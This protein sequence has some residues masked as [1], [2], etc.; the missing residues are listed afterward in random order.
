MSCASTPRT[1]GAGSSSEDAARS[2]PG[3]KRMI[4]TPDGGSFADERRPRPHR[5]FRWLAVA[6]YASFIF[7]LSSIPGGALPKVDLPSFDKLAHTVLF[8]PLAWLL[9]RALLPKRDA[10]ET[11]E[12]RPQWTSSKTA[13][14]IVVA[15]ILTAL[16]GVLDEIHQNFV[17]GRFPSAWDAAAD[18][19][20]ALVG[21]GLWRVEMLW[22]GR[23][24]EIGAGRA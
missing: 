15:I 9:L 19:L 6:V 5:R 22:R 24:R 21:L 1:R 12:S 14:R 17:P 2:P 10:A 8:A 13:L 16:W 3:R 7:A 11:P 4:E 20:G 23:S 18:A